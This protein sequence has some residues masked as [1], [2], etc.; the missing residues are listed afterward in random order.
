M[1]KAVSIDIKSQAE[2]GGGSGLVRAGL[3]L[4]CLIPVDVL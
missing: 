4:A 2:K 1:S 3:L